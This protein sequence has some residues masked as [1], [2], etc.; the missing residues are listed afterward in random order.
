MP[1]NDYG[2]VIKTC[3]KEVDK[4]FA[5]NGW[6]DDERV[7]QLLSVYKDAIYMQIH[8]VL[9]PKKDKVAE[10]EIL[11]I[12]AKYVIGY[13]DRKNKMNYIGSIR[14]IKAKIAQ[15]GKSKKVNR[16]L[17]S[18]YVELYDDFM[19][20]ASFRSF[21]YFCLYIEENYAT[22]DKKIWCYAEKHGLADGM[23]HCFNNMA[24]KGEYKNMFKQTPT[25]YF[26]TYSNIC[27]IAWLFG[28]NKNTDVLYVLGNPSTVKKVFLGV[29]QQMVRPKYAKVFP[30]YQKFGADEGKMF[31]LNNVQ[32]GELLISGANSMCN[33]KVVG[34]DTPIDGTRFKW[35]FYDDIT[36]S[37]DKA[38]AFMH[39][40]DNEMYHDD[41]TKRRYTEYDDYEIF[42]GTA[43]NLRDL[44]CT[45]KDNKGADKAVPCQFKF[46][47]IN[48]DTRT[49]FI[50]I[51]KLDYETDE[52][53]LP[54]K[55]STFSARKERERDYETFMAMEQ[56]MPIPPT[57]LPFDWKKIKTYTEL[58]EKAENGG[59]RSNVCRAVL[60]PAR[61]GTDNLS[62][63]I[64][65]QC[66]DLYYLVTCF[67]RH[68]PLDGKMEDGRTALE[69]CCDLII[70]KNV[71]ELVVETNTVSNIKSQIEQILESRGYRACEIKEI[72]STRKK[73]DKIYDNQ[74]TILEYI[75]FPDKSM[76][77]TSSMM[78]QYM[79][80]IT[81]WS[82]NTKQ[83][84]DS[85]DTEAIFSDHFIRGRMQK[86]A[87][88]RLLYL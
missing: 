14:P 35:R 69:H 50:Q 36:R 16:E 74:S 64:H 19:A 86:S 6:K 87:K 23:W 25:G 47:T 34:K 59:K 46:C 79:K 66:D 13:V 56:Q 52:S 67:Y 73:A 53:T 32:D 1:E 29:K 71:V 31:V 85:I 11:D 38:N 18:R 40:K 39:D 12:I 45:Q 84:D 48:T 62:L 55:Y 9:A 26:K 20:L 82:A 24:L 81:G 44:I 54:E 72:Y 8:H 2:G 65:S 77:G 33:L 7:I 10:K 5:G 80:D 4:L 61:I 57:G 17:L 22:E 68:T 3:A 83:N 37:K 42:S 15:I 63:G 75:V 78:G 28:L 88:A 70:E 58:P 51:P 43:Y 76:Y 21:K 60:D 49:M 30:D 41:W 27:F